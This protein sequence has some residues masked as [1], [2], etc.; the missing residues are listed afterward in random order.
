M[1]QLIAQLDITEDGY[2]AYADWIAAML[3]W[4]S[5]QVRPGGSARRV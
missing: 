4:R 2:I 5:L 3:E 1:Q